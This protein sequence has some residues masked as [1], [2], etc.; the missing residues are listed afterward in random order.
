MLKKRNAKRQEEE[1]KEEESGTAGVVRKT[2][3]QLRLEKEFQEIEL[4][5]YAKIDFPDT[6]NRM[7]FNVQIDLTK[8]H[9][10]MWRGGKFQF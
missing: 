9:D 1:K 4:P 10:S 5:D 6:N 7:K 3:A 2:G 8:E